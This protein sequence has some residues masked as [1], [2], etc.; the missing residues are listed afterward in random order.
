MSELELPEGVAPV[1]CIYEIKNYRDE[2]GHNLVEHVAVSG[3]LPGT[4]TRFMGQ[5]FVNVQARGGPAQQI[6]VPLFPIEA[7][8]VVRA[9]SLFEGLAVVAATA[10]RDTVV[11][12]QQR[13]QPVSPQQAQQLLGPDG[14][15]LNPS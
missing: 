13:V 15:Y 10:F 5:V 11:R 4:M 8:T 1:P 3:K 7:D 2:E 9:F 14:N 6:P 12:Q